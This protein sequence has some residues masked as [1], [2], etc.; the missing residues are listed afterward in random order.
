MTPSS[1]FACSDADQ[2]SGHD[3]HPSIPIGIIKTIIV[4]IC[5]ILFIV[6]SAG[7]SSQSKI[8]SGQMQSEIRSVGAKAVL[9]KYYD[10]PACSGMVRLNHAGH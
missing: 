2:H 6:G 7:A 10:A 5:L 3:E 8:S 9:Q 1:T 4:C